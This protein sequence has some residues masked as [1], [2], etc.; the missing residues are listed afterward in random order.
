MKFHSNISWAVSILEEGFVP[1]SFF[2]FEGGYGDLLSEGGFAFAMR[3][4]R[5][6]CAGDSLLLCGGFGVEEFFFCADGGL[7]GVD[8]FLFRVDGGLFGVD[9]FLFR[10]DGEFFGVDTFLFRADGGLFGVDTFL[11]RADGELFGVDTFFFRADG[12][13]RMFGWH[14]RLLGYDHC[15]LG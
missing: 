1:A 14:P 4:I 7:F 10:A 15:L 6:W 11:F 2:C 13:L 5:F 12:L 3:G 9:T 8:T